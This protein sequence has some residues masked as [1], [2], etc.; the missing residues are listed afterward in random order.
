MVTKELRLLLAQV[1]QRRFSSR[2]S[3][4]LIGS[5]KLIHQ[6]F[7]GNL[8][9]SDVLLLIAMTHG[10]LANITASCTT[11]LPQW[12]MCCHVCELSRV[13]DGLMLVVTLRRIMLSMCL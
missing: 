13:Y 6:M 9:S 12:C 10:L 1:G 2:Q 7:I 11:Q 4:L 5:T 8:L 3:W